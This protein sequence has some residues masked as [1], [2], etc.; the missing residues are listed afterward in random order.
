MELKEEHHERPGR[1][2]VLEGRAAGF[3]SFFHSTLQSFQ[4]DG[5]QTQQGADAE[6]FIG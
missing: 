1:H 4:Q 2:E 3:P 6:D 5:L